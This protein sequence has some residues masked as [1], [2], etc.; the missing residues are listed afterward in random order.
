MKKTLLIALL[1]CTTLLTSTPMEAYVQKSTYQD[2][3][4]PSKVN[5]LPRVKCVRGHF[6]RTSGGY[7]HVNPYTRSR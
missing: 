6:K 7:K 5:G 4:K 3:G 2:M 1:A